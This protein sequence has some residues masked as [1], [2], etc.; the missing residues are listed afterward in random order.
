MLVMGCPG[1][2][3]SGTALIAL[4]KRADASFNSQILT[5]GPGME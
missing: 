1:H 2:P 3:Y 4:V 5:D